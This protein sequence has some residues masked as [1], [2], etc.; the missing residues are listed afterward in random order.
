VANVIVVGA[1]V[2]LVLAVVSPPTALGA[3]VAL[4]IGGVLLCGVATGAYIGA[5]L[6]P[7]PRDG[8]MTGLAARGHTIRAVRTGIELTVLATG[9]ALGGTVGVGTLVFA[10]SI[11][12]LAHHFIPWLA[13][14][15]PPRADAPRRRRPAWTGVGAALRQQQLEQDQVQPAVELARDLGQARDAHEAETLVQAQRSEVVSVDAGDH[16]VFPE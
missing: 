8:L 11:G 15:V 13:I 5:G 1:V 16:G 2:D 6:G 10:L 7:G 3:R 14:G 12:P 9:W 4:L